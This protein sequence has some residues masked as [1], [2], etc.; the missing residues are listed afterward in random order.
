MRIQY[1]SHHLILE[2][3]EV[4]LLTELGYDVFSNGAYA[5]PVG[6]LNLPRPGI[7]GMTHYPDWEFLASQS[8]EKILQPELIEPFDVIIFMHQPEALFANWPNIKHK[9]V[10]YRSIGQSLPHIE[11]RLAECVGEGLQIIRYSPF[12]A[13][14]SVYAGDHAVIRFYKDPAEFNGWTGVNK[15]VINFTQNLVGRGEFCHHDE[16]LYVMRDLPAKIYGIENEGLG[17]LN[18]GELTYEDMKQEMRDARAYLYAG[19]W[20]ASYTLSFIE[21]W[22]TG[23]PV[24]SIGNKLAAGRFDAYNFFEV[25]ELMTQG[26][27]GFY[28]DNLNEIKEWVKMLLSNPGQAKLISDNGRNKAIEYFGKEKI[29]AQWKAFLG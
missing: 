20:P 19:T 5:N 24:I 23:I 16:L 6:A 29:A 10:I 15:R 13:R 22:M 8:T 7:T 4:K 21:A 12:E 3:D 18:G 11:S 9:R 28:S 26:V 25:P 14:M 2:W 17:N 27:D 1:I